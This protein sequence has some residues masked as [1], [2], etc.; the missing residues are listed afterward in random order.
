[1]IDD[2]DDDDRAAVGGVRT[3]KGNRSIRRKLALVPL[4]PRKI[5][6]ELT[7]LE[8]GPPRSKADD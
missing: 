3:G 8:P 6:H 5:P 4:R 1:M 2:D 7:R